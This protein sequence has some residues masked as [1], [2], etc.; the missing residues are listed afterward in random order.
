MVELLG[1]ERITNDHY[2]FCGG[3]QLASILNSQTCDS[4]DVLYITRD[5][6][7]KL[8]AASMSPV[9]TKPG[10]NIANT[11]VACSQSRG[12]QEFPHM[13]WVGTADCSLASRS[14]IRSLNE[15]GVITFPSFINRGSTDVAIVTGTNRSS[16]HVICIVE[17]AT[18]PPESLAGRCA[19]HIIVGGDLYFSDESVANYVARSTSMSITLSLNSYLQ[20]SR[21]LNAFLKL[22]D[23]RRL[24]LLCGTEAEFLCLAALLAVPLD[25]LSKTFNCEVISTSGSEGF[26]LWER[27]SSKANVVAGTSVS[28]PASGLGAGDALLGGYLCGRLQGL[29]PLDA[30]RKALDTV[31]PVLRSASARSESQC[32]LVGSPLHSLALECDAIRKEIDWGSR[33]AIV[34]GGQTG[35]DQLAN[36]IAFDN[37][38]RSYRTLPNG[39]R[40]ENGGGVELSGTEPK[41]REFE[42]STSGYR[43]RTWACVY[44]ADATL[45]IAFRSS[46]GTK[47]TETAA[48]QLGRPLFYLDPE[49]SNPIDS[50][51]EILRN[52]VQVLNIAGH[53][54]S[55]LTDAE[56]L[57]SARCL[58]ALITE[59]ARRIP[60]PSDDV[61]NI[62]NGSYVAGARF[63]PLRAKDVG[64]CRIGLPSSGRMRTWLD[65]HIEPR[66]E[67]RLVYGRPQDLCRWLESG[68]IDIGILGSDS[69]LEAGFSGTIFCDFGLFASTILIVGHHS[70]GALPLVA[71]SPNLARQLLHR[72]EEEIH[73]ITGCA[74]TWI[75]LG[76]A[77]RAMDTWH[78]G[79]TARAKN[80]NPIERLSS[81]SLVC[82]LRHGIDA[83]T[84]DIAS[85]FVERVFSVDVWRLYE[86]RRRRAWHSANVLEQMR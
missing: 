31:S 39:K 81:T 5:Q 21:N 12:H 45:M 44:I 59:L 34:S 76:L 9:V 17:G 6:F 83:R 28:D 85:R 19:D 7:D 57:T 53:R 11:L 43:D 25:S 22:A 48:R 78:T 68:D 8:T 79:A 61:A 14:A 69:L 47:E 37:G 2:V 42:I 1:I 3:Q 75:E 73:A 40:T 49:R 72:R 67:V 36:Q 82:A 52:G 20:D 16:G 15:H 24:F 27:G 65:G 55:L 4:D 54:R 70:R 35:I 33:L 84:E 66:E 23:S 77:D 38:V 10:G 64:I 62:V 51:N 29:P 41:G 63:E 58:Q 86:S 26:R 56:V 18:V 13:V 80:L 30:S 60:S 71:Q 32:I 46:P 74:E 50:A